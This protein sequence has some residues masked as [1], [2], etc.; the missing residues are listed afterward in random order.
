MDSAG[1]D[2]VVAALAIGLATALMATFGMLIGR[3]LGGRFDVC[4]H[5]RFSGSGGCHRGWFGSGGVSD[6]RLHDS[7]D[8]FRQPAT[9]LAGPAL[10]LA[11]RFRQ[12]LAIVPD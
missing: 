12:A 5:R 10:F 6:H 8:P 2:I 11:S 4:C 1:A 3:F 9:N 7:G